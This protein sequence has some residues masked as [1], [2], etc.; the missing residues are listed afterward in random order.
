[1]SGVSGNCLKGPEMPQLKLFGTKWL[2]L[3]ET[4]PSL[5]GLDHITQ[6]WGV[7]WRC[8]KRGRSRL[9]LVFGWSMAGGKTESLNGLSSVKLL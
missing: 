2:P 7:F 9:M 8:A 4:E 5:D 3:V 1:M 6:P